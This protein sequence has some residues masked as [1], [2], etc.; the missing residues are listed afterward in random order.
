M[1]YRPKAT[2]V[3]ISQSH[4]ESESK[5]TLSVIILRLYNEGKLLQ[6]LTW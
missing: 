5:V 1:I 6:S 3:R 4:E 2:V